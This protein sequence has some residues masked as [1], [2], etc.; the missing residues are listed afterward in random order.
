MRDMMRLIDKVQPILYL[1]VILAALIGCDGGVGSSGNGRGG[2]VNDT[3]PGEGPP[4][5]EGIANSKA[6][7]APRA[8][9]HNI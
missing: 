3:D 4:A 1:G 8:T 6:L 7:S 5:G 2:P 9:R